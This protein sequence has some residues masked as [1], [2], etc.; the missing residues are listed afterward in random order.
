MAGKK[1]KAPGRPLFG[2]KAKKTAQPASKTGQE[3]SRGAALNRRSSTKKSPVAHRTAAKSAPRKPSVSRVDQGASADGAVKRTRKPRSISLLQKVFRR[4]ASLPV[5][6]GLSLDRK[7][8]I[9]GIFLALLGLL[10]VL[11]LLST[12]NSSITGGWVAG[13][14]ATFGLGM[15]MFAAGL[16]VTGLWLVL[17][18]FERVPQLSVE[19]IVGI[20]LLFVNFLAVIHFLVMQTSGAQ[21]FELAQQS[22]GGG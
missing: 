17:R 3:R 16:I 11:S 22:A 1:R 6:T 5:I 7:L 2:G 19:R 18:N 10:T 8:D 13:L 9:V 12:N 14:R 15:Y 21:A 4:R 20:L